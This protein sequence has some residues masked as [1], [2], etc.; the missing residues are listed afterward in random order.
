MI[1]SYPVGGVLWDYGQYLLG[2]ERL[3]FEVTY[4]E[5][6]GWQT[7]DPRVGAYGAD[8]SYGVDFLSR[9]LQS[10]SPSLAQRWCFRGMDGRDYGP[11]A[12]HIDEQVREADLF[13]NVSGSAVLRS[14]YLACPR[15]VLIDTDPGWNHFRNYPLQDALAAVKR[16]DIGTARTLLIGAGH[17]ERAEDTDAWLAESTRWRDAGTFRDHDHFFTYAERLGRSGCNLPTFDLPWKPTRPPVVL[18]CWK[19]EPPGAKWTTVMSW[20]NFREPVRHDGAEYGSKEMEFPTIEAL[21]GLV[22][23]DCEVAVGGEDAPRDQ[24]RRHGWSVIEAESASGTP[25]TYRSYVQRSR[26]EISVAKNLYV[27]T[28]SGWF[29]CRSVCYL[30]AGRPVVVQDTGFSELLPTGE[31]LLAFSDLDGAIDAIRRVEQ[32]YAGHC[33]AARDVAAREFDATRVLTDLIS[34]TGLK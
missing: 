23:V 11:A 13:L 8:C 3:G 31:G 34:N 9:G 17:A 30:A 12:E 20:N 32:D 2:L 29:S 28:G 21:P 7:Y 33:D 26:G 14:A 18:D 4:L 25:E 10:L 19:A 24:W 1:A 5:D 15:K 22:D 27:A 6:T 16:G